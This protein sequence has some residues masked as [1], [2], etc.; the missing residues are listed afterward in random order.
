MISPGIQFDPAFESLTGHKPLAWQRRLFGRLYSG[1][2]VPACVDLPTGL[3][4]TSVI[5]IF[6]IALARQAQ[7]GRVALPRRL[8]YVV[9][10]RTV[11]DQA[12]IM[13]EQIRN[14]LRNPNDD[15]NL[16]ALSAGLRKLLSSDQG[17]LLA[18]STLRGEL[19]DNQE[20]KADPA[21]PAVIVGTIDMIGSKLLFSG[22]GDGRYSRAQHA[23]LVGH[24]SLIV[25]DEAHLTPAFGDLLRQVAKVQRQAHEP[26]G[27]PVGGAPGQ[28]PLP[29]HQRRYLAG[30]GPESERSLPHQV[31]VDL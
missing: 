19:A 23:G 6:V 24:D 18:V 2:E 8:V 15:P 16:E 22:Y 25:H 9:N 4:K 20:W 3:G 10:R 12:T 1:P 29:H 21:R 5:P 14:R 11:V 28:A 7:D 31:G 13:V 26:L 30:R 27:D 17:E